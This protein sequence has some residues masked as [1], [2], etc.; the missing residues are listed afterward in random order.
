MTREEKLTYML[1]ISTRLQEKD[2]VFLKKIY[3]KL[4][5][6]LYFIRISVMDVSKKP[7]NNKFTLKEENIT[8]VAEYLAE[9][10][11]IDKGFYKIQT[12][13]RW[14]VQPRQIMHTLFFDNSIMSLEH[15]GKKIGKRDHATVIHS[16]K[17]VDNMIETDSGFMELYDKIL[18]KLNLA[19]HKY[20]T[21]TLRP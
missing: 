8:Y 19:Y 16:H 15:I 2:T 5:E 10:F 4:L 1:K 13:K 12:N 21:R 20:L 9:L 7:K 17:A 11:G 14:V 18:N 3:N 6:S